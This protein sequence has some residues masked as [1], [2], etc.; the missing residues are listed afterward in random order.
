MSS[1]FNSI[2]VKPILNVLLLIYH[3]LLILHIPYPLGFSIIGLTIVIRLI[4]YP[5]T[6]SYLKTSAKMQKIAPHLSRLKEKHKSDAKR[7]QSETMKL[8]KEHGVNPAA[9]CLPSLVQLPIIWGLYA[10]LQKVVALG[11]QQTVAYINGFSYFNF[12]RISRSWDQNFFGVALGKHPSEI[13]SV[14]PLVVLVPFLTGFFQ[15]I[16]SKMMFLPQEQ[17]DIKKKEEKKEDF[18]SSFQSQSM[19]IFPVMI[20]FFSYSFPIGLSLYWNTFTIFAILQQYRIQGF[21]GLEPWIKA[22]NEKIGRNSKKK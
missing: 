2:L 1:L 21:G 20:G 6:S 9:G 13:L 16:Q 22:L 15:F 18:A 7:L 8:Y 12:L 5:L 11:P 14:A 3:G 17:I 10:V 19:Y 4:L